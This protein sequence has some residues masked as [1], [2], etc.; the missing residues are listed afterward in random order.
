M[1]VEVQLDLFCTDATALVGQAGGIYRYVLGSNNA[2]AIVDHFTSAGDIRLNSHISVRGYQVAVAVIQAL[3][4][5]DQEAIGLGA[6][7]AV[8][9]GLAAGFDSAVVGLQYACMVEQILGL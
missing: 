2:A 1:T 5:G 3:A 7:L 4:G 9:E 6:S 8:V